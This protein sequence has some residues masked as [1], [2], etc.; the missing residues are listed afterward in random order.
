M[1]IQNLL[2]PYVLLLNLAAGI[3]EQ[4]N[5]QQNLQ[6]FESIELVVVV[7]FVDLGLRQKYIGF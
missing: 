4:H 3:A 7:L 1:T 2:V 5:A 6:P